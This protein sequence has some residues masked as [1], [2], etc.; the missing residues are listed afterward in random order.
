MADDISTDKVD[1]VSSD[2]DG[3]ADSGAGSA[4]PAAWWT[5][6]YLVL[7]LFAVS[8]YDWNTTFD[9]STTLS[10]NDG[11]ALLFGTLLAANVVVT[12]FL[13]VVLPLLISTYLWSPEGRR[14]VIVLPT[15]LVR[16]RPTA[17]ST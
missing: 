15:A 4:V 11:L 10:V 8:G 5:F 17:A 9:V 16:L 6:A 14:A 12:V 3:D 2:D 13:I 7:R 1:V